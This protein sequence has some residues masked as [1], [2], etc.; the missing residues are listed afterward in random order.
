MLGKSKGV[1]FQTETLPLLVWKTRFSQMLIRL[2]PLAALE[3]YKVLTVPFLASPTLFPGP[4]VPSERMCFPDTFCEAGL[5]SSERLQGF[6]Q[7]HGVIR[8]VC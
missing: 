4:A 5:G 8:A 6:L 7:Q 3:F 1:P 2:V